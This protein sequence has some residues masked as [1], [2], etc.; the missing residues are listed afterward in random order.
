GEAVALTPDLRHPTHPTPPVR[1]P[2]I[3]TYAHHRG[4][5]QWQLVGLIT[6][7]S[8]VRILPPLPP[9]ADLSGLRLLCICQPTY[10]DKSL[11]R[12]SRR[13]CLR[14]YSAAEAPAVLAGCHR[15]P[16]RSAPQSPVRRPAQ[17]GPSARTAR[18]PLRG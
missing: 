16:A 2:C 5:E 4:V 15:A 14:R 3:P 18:L 7:R 1:H 9:A 13:A 12:S 6:Q 17:L 10:I 11:R 8:Q